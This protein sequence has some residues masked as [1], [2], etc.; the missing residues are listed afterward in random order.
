[1]ATTPLLARS[2]TSLLAGGGADL[3]LRPCRAAL[4]VRRLR[5]GWRAR[6][7][8]HRGLPRLQAVKLELDGLGVLMFFL[9]AIAAM[10]GVLEATLRER[11]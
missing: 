8:A 4:L 5:H 7:A 11:C 6:A 9:F 3:P 1:M 10:D 2:F